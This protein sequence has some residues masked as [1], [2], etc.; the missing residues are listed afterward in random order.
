MAKCLQT[1]K[2]Y[3]K[4]IAHNVRLTWEQ[5]AT[6][7]IE[8]EAIWNSRPLTAISNNPNDFTALTPGH[9]LI[10]DSMN[11][12]PERNLQSLP[13]NRLKAWELLV[14]VKQDFWKRWHTNI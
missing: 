4:R 10:C 1:I 3:F 7:I 8:I 11:A 12:L 14:K 6:L 5:F 13:D 9:F 2:Y